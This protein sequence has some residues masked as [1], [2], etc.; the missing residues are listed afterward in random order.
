MKT[1]FLD[2]PDWSWHS[3]AEYR[4]SVPN[5]EL[6]S[7][8]F[9]EV[10]DLLL[11]N[12]NLNSSHV[13]RADILYDSS[14]KLRTKTEREH[15]LGH[16][17]RQETSTNQF[18][19]AGQADELVLNSVLPHRTVVRKLIPR[20]QNLDKP[21][22]Q[23]CLFYTL[24]E[25]VEAVVYVPQVKSEDQMPWYHPKVRALAY[26][27]GTGIES[28]QPTL[29]VH[30]ASFRDD[31][32]LLV[33][34]RLHRT[35][36][37]LLNTFLRLARHKSSGQNGARVSHD[38]ADDDIDLRPATIKDNIV[39]QHIVQDTYARLKTTYASK[40]IA[41]WVEET[42]ADKHV[43]EDLAI[44]AFLICLWQKLYSSP[45]TFSGFVDMACGNGLLVH[46]LIQEG[47]HGIGLD[48][49]R[50]K[51]WASLGLGDVV[52]ERVIIPK[53]F[54]DQLNTTHDQ[55]G[56]TVLV[57]TP[58]L[59]IHDGIFKPGTFLIAN[60]ADELTIWTP[61]LAA[62]SCSDQPLPF[63]NIPCCS[64]ALS[65]EK[66]RYSP[67]DTRVNEPIDL[68]SITL[69]QPLT[70]NSSNDSINDKTPQPQSGD[71]KSLR[72]EKAQQSNLINGP[73]STP[74]PTSTTD[75]SMYA[76]LT[77]KAIQLSRQL[78]LAV[79]C[80]LMRIPSTRNIGIVHVGN[81][82]AQPH[83]QFNSPLAQ[84]RDDQQRTKNRLNAVTAIIALECQRTGGLQRS[85]EVWV[86]RAQ[87]LHVGG[88]GRGERGKVN[89]GGPRRMV[90]DG[91]GDRDDQLSQQTSTS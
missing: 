43:F 8:K 6:L 66:H 3:S 51:T 39:P 68:T 79:K 50:R 58:D 45:E 26:V 32:N 65:G 56:E 82:A 2:S 42:P 81:I 55:S 61:L 69:S 16:T 37:S 64:H 44:A 17:S 15:E 7:P 13:F 89:L 70:D 14:G 22:L 76:C 20:N 30:Y 53:P 71:L 73:S 19:D 11:E 33:P 63:L 83:R 38:A 90:S 21:L 80:T 60:H 31:Q 72:A 9:R 1:P 29:S 28:E 25:G 47:W 75:K 5:K 41:A 4:A 52:Q 18:K 27:Y 77:K 74:K 84:R 59:K 86:A 23:T 54:I 62:L 85:A 78:D 49:R 67:K 57:D 10:T 35:L 88:G 12:P 24:Q 87:K 40:L 48:A 34:E 91:A 36:L 46:I